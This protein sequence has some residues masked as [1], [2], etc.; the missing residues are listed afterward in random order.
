MSPPT[1]DDIHLNAGFKKVNGR[2]MSRHM[3]RNPTRGR[4]RGD[5]EK[6]GMVP[7]PFVDSDAR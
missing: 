2:R 1:A 6:G 5:F 4:L 3:R 7:H